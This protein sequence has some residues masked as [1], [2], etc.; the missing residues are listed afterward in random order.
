MVGGIDWKKKTFDVMGV[1][2]AMNDVW[3]KIGGLGK[4]WALEQPNRISDSC[5]RI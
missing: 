3:R 2:K 4:K 1:R 5:L